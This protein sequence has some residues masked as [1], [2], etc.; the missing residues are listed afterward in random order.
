MALRY[1]VEALLY[2]YAPTPPPDGAPAIPSGIEQAAGK[3]PPEF[4]ERFRKPAGF[5][6]LLAYNLI[7]E[8]EQA[9]PGEINEWTV[10]IFLNAKPGALGLIRSGLGLGQ[11]TK[12]KVK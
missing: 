2:H 6:H 9:A 10:P 4:A 8:I 1:A 5:G 11:N 7:L 12:G 3:M